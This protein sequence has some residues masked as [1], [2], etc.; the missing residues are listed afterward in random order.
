[1]KR[2]S[3]FL[4]TA[5]MA[6]IIMPAEAYVPV[7]VSASRVEPK[8][9]LMMLEGVARKF[10]MAAIQQKTN[11]STTDRIFIAAVS[12][13]G[14][15]RDIVGENYKAIDSLVVKGPIDASDFEF[16]R[17]CCSFGSV[18]GINLEDADVKD[19]KIPDCAFWAR[20]ENISYFLPL[21]SITLP[22]GIVE[23]GEKAF[24][25]TFL[26]HINFPSTLKKLGASCFCYSPYITG[27]ILIP[28]GVSEIPDRCF[29]NVGSAGHSINITL[30]STIK[31]IGDY[32]FDTSFIRE[33]NLPEG[34][35]N[36]GYRAFYSCWIKDITLPESCMNYSSIIGTN[37]CGVFELCYD[38]KEM[39][40][41]EGMVTIP[42][43]IALNTI[44]VEKVNIPEGVRS[45]G[46]GSFRNSKALAKVDFPNSLVE[47]LDSAF[48]ESGLE[49]L[50]IPENLTYLA[51]MSFAN[52]TK[53]KRIV[54]HSQHPPL[55]ADR[56]INGGNIPIYAFG[57]DS[58]TGTPHNIPV[59]VPKGS[60]QNYAGDM[61]GWQWFTNFIEMDDVV[62]IDDISAGEDGPGVQTQN[63]IILIL[64]P[65]GQPLIYEAYSVDGRMVARGIT[66]GI[67]TQ[68]D[69]PA[70]FY[71]LRASGKTFKV[72]I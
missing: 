30:P 47:V 59:Y 56:N 63:G 65:D 3:V 35:E 62:G 13:Y 38:L 31:R 69:L 51:P 40:F 32:A 37:E 53:L 20:Y 14:T 41:A 19:K 33:I 6:S 70:G 10:D 22:D 72:R 67:S 8:P 11:V 55:A 34:L 21:Q 64:T 50:E 39:N 48:F 18:R 9:Q 60:M 26:R 24:F 54:C 71:I 16:M 29:V 52:N 25:S 68:V 46:T 15:L 7:A 12:E 44:A 43:K 66:S 17:D 45:V 57:D 42:S 23:F 1:M 36:V 28:E 5:L 27:D 58:H 49:E 2:L 61:L 4:L